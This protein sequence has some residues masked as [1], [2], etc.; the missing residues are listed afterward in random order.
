MQVDVTEFV[1][2]KIPQLL[3][4]KVEAKKAKDE[5]KSQLKPQKNQAPIQLD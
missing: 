2:D 3:L 1:R 4:R 5:A